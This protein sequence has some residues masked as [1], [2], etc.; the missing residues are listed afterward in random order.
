M[1]PSSFAEVPLHPLIVGQLSGKN[2]TRMPS[3]ESNSGLPYSQ[4]WE[5]PGFKKKKTSPVGFLGFFVFLGF[6]GFLG[7][8][9][10]FSVSQ[11][12]LGASRH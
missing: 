9:G 4:G 12:L 8:F 2:L 3:R 6:L 10:F 7:F 1:H 5:K 11:I